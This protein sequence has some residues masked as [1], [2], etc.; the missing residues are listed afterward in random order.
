[1]YSVH[2]EAFLFLHGLHTKV[3]IDHFQGTVQD[4]EHQIQVLPEIP[5]YPK[6]SQNTDMFSSGRMALSALKAFCNK[7]E[8]RWMMNGD[9]DT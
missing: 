1:M 5:K 8:G 3:C 2:E 9:D 6:K 4:R 7:V